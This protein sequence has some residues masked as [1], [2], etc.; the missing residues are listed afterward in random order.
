MSTANT[1]THTDVPQLIEQRLDAIDQALVGLLPRQ[2]RLATVAHIESRIRELAATNTANLPA[3]TRILA[4]PELAFSNLANQTSTFQPH[5]QFFGMAPGGWAPAS[6]KKRSRL[7]ISAGVLGILALMLLIST[8][9]TYFIVE[10]LAEVLGEIGAIALMAVHGVAITFG[11]LAAV[12]LGICAIVVL[13]RRRDQLAGHGWAIAGL[14]TG[15]LPMMLG[16]TALLLV[17]LQFGL[18]AIMTAFESNAVSSPDHATVAD[19]AD[20]SSPE[21]HGPVQYGISVQ[22]IPEQ[23]LPPMDPYEVQPAGHE[24]SQAT[25]AH[26]PT[27]VSSGVPTPPVYTAAPTGEPGSRPTSAPTEPQPSPRAAS[28]PTEPQPAPRPEAPAEPVAMP[29]SAPAISK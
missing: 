15:A 26:S 9:V 11:G 29:E 21:R 2:D 5:P 27:A 23:N 28:A 3:T 16:C 19:S 12:G 14:C 10:M 22:N 20:E 24:S 18:G 25:P 13:R 6:V 8:P 17:G 7:A 4:R 1:T